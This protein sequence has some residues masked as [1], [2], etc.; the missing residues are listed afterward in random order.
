V[1]HLAADHLAPYNAKQARPESTDTVEYLL[2]N[3]YL[4]HYLALRPSTTTATS[5]FSNRSSRTSAKRLRDFGTVE[6]EHLLNGFD[7]AGRG[8]DEG[9]GES[10]EARK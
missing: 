6:T 4:P 1:R 9:I 2:E 10:V 7:G 5:T 8:R 3:V